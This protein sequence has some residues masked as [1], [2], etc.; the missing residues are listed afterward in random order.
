MKPA[1]LGCGRGYFGG[2][3]QDRP[4]A[5]VRHVIEL[6]KR[7]VFGRTNSHRLNARLWQG[8]LR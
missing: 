8:T 6:L 3:E 2:L 5:L 7:L 4:C 1:V